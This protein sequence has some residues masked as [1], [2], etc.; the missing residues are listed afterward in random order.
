MELDPQS[1]TSLAEIFEEWI[2]VVARASLEAQR[3]EGLED[4]D[5]IIQFD[6]GDAGAWHIGILGGAEVAVTEGL[7]EAPQLAFRMNESAFRRTQLGEGRR[8][9]IL[10]MITGDRHRYD[11]LVQVRGTLSLDLKEGRDDRIGV[12]VVFG[13]ASDPNV[14]LKAKFDDFCDIVERKGNPVVMYMTGR[15]KAHGSLGLLLKTQQVL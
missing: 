5:L 15:I 2:P 6:F 14:T 11:K 13:G 9:N 10:G 3:P 12:D 4:V 8:W 7:H 1:D